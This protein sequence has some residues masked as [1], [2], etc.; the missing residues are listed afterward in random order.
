VTVLPEGADH[1]RRAR[2]ALRVVALVAVIAAASFT[3]VAIRDH[4]SP[5]AA[6]STTDGSSARAQLSMSV[7]RLLAGST[8]AL[9]LGVDASPAAMVHLLGARSQLSTSQARALTG[10]SITVDV[11]A[12]AGRSIEAWTRH[13]AQGGS[14]RFAL[15]EYGRP[16]IQLVGVGGRLY[17]RVDV[18][19]VIDFATN[20]SEYRRLLARSHFPASIRALIHGRWVAI[21]SAASSH[22]LAPTPA[23]TEIAATALPRDLLRDVTVTEVGR[24][25]NGEHLAIHLDTARF[26]TD[27][28]KAVGSVSPL[29]ALGSSSLPRLP[30]SGVP[31]TADAWITHQQLSR[32]TLDVTQ[33][34]RDRPLPTSSHVVLDL[35]LGTATAGPAIPSTSIHLSPLQ[36]ATVFSRLTEHRR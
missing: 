30:V 28:F 22:E 36:I 11:A 8:L 3:I 24:T 12:P 26:L 16:A 34:D 4:D 14:V 35:R 6:S 10:A 13:L 31:L 20:P 25:S 15:N 27:A 18:N 21:N 17:A 7:Q 33:F 29:G 9:T 19:R 1:P 23:P 2:V 32:V 5:R